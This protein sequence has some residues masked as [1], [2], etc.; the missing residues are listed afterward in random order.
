MHPASPIRPD[1]TAHSFAVEDINV[2][3]LGLIPY[4][5]AWDL[6]RQLQQELIAGRQGPV[7]LICEHQPVI[8]IGRSGKAA[9]II[10]P[11]SEL[12]ALGVQVVEVERG[13]DVTYHGPGQ[14]VAYPILNLSSRRRDV[15]WYMRTLEES[16]I[17]TLQA[18]EVVGVRRQGRTGVWT[19]NRKNATDSRPL[20]LEPNRKIA[21]IGVR[22]SRW[23]TLHGLSLNVRNCQ[24]G[25]RLIN[26]CGFTD[27][28]ATSME[29]EGAGTLALSVVED[30][31]VPHFLE[32]FG[33]RQI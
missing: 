5:E 3:R 31:F 24:S 16:V 11:P 29:E 26:P 20:A 21:S 9:N 13:G 8:T 15:G 28:A 6:Q 32:L 22:I 2:R 7:L 33:Y 19:E 23:C 30:R 18:F 25:F 27:I 17:R 10:A 1:T 14:L 12:A 4:Q